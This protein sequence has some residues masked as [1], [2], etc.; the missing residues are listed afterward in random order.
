MKQAHLIDFPM[1]DTWLDPQRPLPIFRGSYPPGSAWGGLERILPEL[2]RLFCREDR[3]RALEFGVEWGYSTAALAQLFSEVVGVD[4]F[5]GDPHSGFK[6]DHLKETRANL[7]A[8]SNIRL[9]QQNFRNFIQDQAFD[10]RYS[11]I[12][13]DMMHDFE[14]T[15][16]AGRWAAAHAPVVLFHDTES[17]WPEVKQAVLEIAEESGRE[18]YNYPKCYGLGILF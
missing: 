16:T 12:H 18:V 4:T 7:T 2:V 1:N 8:W 6:E 3:G 13:I 14:T 5:R 9:V 17:I 15:Y 11:L 10:S